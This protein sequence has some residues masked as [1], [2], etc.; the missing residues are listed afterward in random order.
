MGFGYLLIGYLITHVLYLTLNGLGIGGL[1]LL[2]GYAVMLMGLKELTHFHASFA[3]AKWMLLPMAI[4][5]LYDTA[6]SL[7]TMLLWR[8]P[9]FS[10]E[11]VAVCD[12]ISFAL[13]ILFNVMLL[14][15]VKMISNMVG[16]G[17]MSTAAIRN[18][19]F[20]CIHAMVA[21]VAMLPVGLPD[22]TQRLLAFASMLLNVVWVVCNLLLL[23][24]CNK[25][26][27]RQGDED[28]AP[29]P[30]RLKWFNKI[31][32]IYEKNKQM[33]IDSTREYAEDVLRRRQEAREKKRK[34][35]K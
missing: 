25:N 33:T 34:R 15:A 11:A 23:L 24:A 27:C 12:A 22:E 5:A 32:G 4:L 16:I 3:G 6:A 30:S 19:V 13:N 9:V 10:A 17:S 2:V 21:T 14:Y 31:D 29:R 1:A 26:I 35:K 20:V 18:I 28:Q 8:L 7:D